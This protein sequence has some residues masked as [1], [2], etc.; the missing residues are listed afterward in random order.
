MILIAVGALIGTWIAGGVVPT[1]I[2][3]GLEFIHPSIFLLA[4]L[5]IC[6]ITSVATGTS[7]GTVGTAGIAMMAIGEGLGLPLPLVAGAVLSGA[8]FGDKLSPLSDSTVLASS[9]SKVEVITHVRA[10]LYL[11]IPA[12]LITAVLFTITGFMY[13]SRNVDLEKLNFESFFAEHV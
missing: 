12:Y 4:T 7:W 9:L 1:L 5:I 6:S 2:Y 8:Y 11:S 13:G 10:M 3:Y